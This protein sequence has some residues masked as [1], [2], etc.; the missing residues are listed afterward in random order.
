MK[1]FL[2]LFV[3]LLFFVV[4]C[5]NKV[6]DSEE[7][8]ESNQKTEVQQLKFAYGD[9]NK[10]EKRYEYN[11]TYNFN[12]NSIK[13]LDGAIVFRVGFYDSSKYDKKTL[14]DMCSEIKKNDIGVIK[15]EA[16]YINSYTV[17][18]SGAVVYINIKYDVEKIEEKFDGLFDKET[19]RENLKSILEKEFKE[20]NALSVTIIDDK[21]EKLS[22]KEQV[23]HNTNCASSYCE[24]CDYNNNV[25]DCEYE[26]Q[27]GVK[28]KI[29]C[30]IYRVN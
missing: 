6:S 3:I 29:I 19:N 7:N 13:S 22:L 14:D 25:C 26:N 5:G 21:E 16:K 11:F 17:S 8:S 10:S 4:G 24:K 9:L 2:G 12:G 30:E 23:I 18:P 1:K 28:E 15:C 27:N 20:S